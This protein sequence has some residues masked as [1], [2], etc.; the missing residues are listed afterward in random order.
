[1]QLRFDVIV[2]PV[3]FTQTEVKAVLAHLHGTCHLMASL[4]Y[5]AGLRVMECVRLRTKDLDFAYHQI[6]VCDGKGAKD[7]VTMLPSSLT[8]TLQRHLAKTKLLHAE[9]LAEG[10]GAVYLPYALERKYP[11][12]ATEWGCSMFSR[13]P[14][15]PSIPAP[16]LCVV[17][18]SQKMDSSAR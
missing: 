17:T 2:V 6:T 9:D 5:G 15:A 13:H 10:F 1:M 16:V 14:D 12:A 7:R 8:E 18:T 3:V 11:T 4:L